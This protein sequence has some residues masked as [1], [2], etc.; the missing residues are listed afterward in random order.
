M[1]GIAVKNGFVFFVIEA[2][3]SLRDIPLC[4][5][6]VSAI[7]SMAFFDDRVELCLGINFAETKASLTSVIF[8]EDIDVK[9]SAPLEVGKCRLVVGGNAADQLKQAWF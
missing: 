7:E 5:F 9:I 3:Y 8:S 4:G 2:D 6:P 1:I